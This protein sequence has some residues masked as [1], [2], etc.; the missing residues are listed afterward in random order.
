[1]R[2]GILTSHPIQY[3]APW[4]RALAQVADVEV[5]FAHRQSA[6]EQGQAG[7]G[8]AF[9]WDVDLLSGYNHHFLK[10]ISVQPSVNVYA[11]CD[12][13]EIGDIISGK[14]KL[15]KQKAEI[16]K[17]KAE[18]GKL[19]TEIRGGKTES[20]KQKAEMEGG[21]FSSQ[22]SVAPKH[23]EGGS[24]FN[25]SPFDV[26]IVNGWYLKSYRQAVRACRAA[27]IPVLVRG[28]SQLG[29]PRAWFKRL[30]MEVKQR[31]LLRQFDGF[32]TVGQRNREYLEHFGVPPAKIF[33]VPHFVDN[34]WF[35][36]RANQARGVG[37]VATE[38]KDDRPETIDESPKSEVQS[39]RSA[40]RAKWGADEHTVVALFVGKFQP[41]KRP[42]DL[43]RAMARL[44]GK[45]A[46]SGKP[47]TEIGAFQ[48]STFNFQLCH[49]IVAVFVGAGELEKEL[50][51]EAENLGLM[52]KVE[53]GADTADRGKPKAEIQNPQL[54]SGNIQ[55][56]TFNIQHSSVQVCFAG[57]KN[58][59]ELP[60][61]YAA[62]DVLVLPS[63][64]GETWGLV[65]NEAMACGLPAIVSDAV[66]C[67]P[68]LIEEGKTGWTFPLGDTEAL[69]ERLMALA[70]MKAAG[71]NFA[72]ALKTKLQT[73]S[74]A[75]AVAETVRAAEIV[76]RAKSR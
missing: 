34:E 29:T 72:S 44:K 57:F 24:T 54:E 62:A 26:F 73:Y 63:D 5:F 25:S 65:V 6:A 8:Q 35:A 22:L 10:N 53:G 12:T 47:K 37:R 49:N 1:M 59:S 27:G 19:K 48:P 42:L 46:E 75:T 60:G 2:L 23:G 11:G 56:S 71:H 45:K 66:G 43:I 58:Q 68:D 51:E 52:E 41:K 28:D 15:G 30:G 69:A 14:Q 13:P 9:E 39:P 50:R 7:F 74:L 20:E 76:T 67:A 4:F 55:H 16:Q 33:F 70:K 18:S 32:L 64:G 3:Q 17:A 38:T 61:C 40:L 21:S 31:W 36:R